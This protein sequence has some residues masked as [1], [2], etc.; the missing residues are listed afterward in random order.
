MSTF[1]PD[2]LVGAIA[3]VYLSHPD[4]MDHSS[5]YL[6]CN[7]NQL[8]VNLIILAL[9]FT[10]MSESARRS[11]VPVWSEDDHRLQNQASIRRLSFCSSQSNLQLSKI[12]CLSYMSTYIDRL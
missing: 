10:S 7:K 1:L 12:C 3:T 2:I 5:C 9:S 8:S 6:L 4:I 11:R